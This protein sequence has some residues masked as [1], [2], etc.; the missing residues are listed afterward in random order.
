[1]RHKVRYL[2]KMDR[3]IVG[4][5][6]QVVVE[7]YHPSICSPVSGCGHRRRLRQPVSI[8]IRIISPD[9]PTPPFD[10]LSYDARVARLE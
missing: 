10:A 9:F 1:M 2:P 6:L 8:A 4:Y 3:K 5:L 7:L